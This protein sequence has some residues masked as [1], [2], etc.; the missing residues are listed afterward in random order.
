MHTN[1]Q[2]KLT[3]RNNSFNSKSNS[4]NTFATIITINFDELAMFMNCCKFRAYIL[5]AKGI[6]S[7]TEFYKWKC[8]NQNKSV[9]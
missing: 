9:F 4:T 1:I 8:S 7:L 6:L 5:G 3:E 2:T